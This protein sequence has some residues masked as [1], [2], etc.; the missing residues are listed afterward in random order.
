MY[1]RPHGADR[2][3]HFERVA[4]PVRQSAAV[5]VGAPVRQ[6]RDERREQVAV[7]AVQ[8][9]QIEA[10]AQ[11]HLRG[12]HELLLHAL[13]VVARHRARR[14]IPL[15]VRDRRGAEQRPVAV[16]ERLV[17]LLPAALRRAF[18]SGVAELQRDLRGRVGV[19]EV[20]D[21]RPGR[22]VLLAVHPRA[23]RRD[24]RVG[25]DARHL[26]EHQARAALSARAQVDEIEVVRQ[27]VDA[28]VHRHRRDDDAVRQLELAQ[29]QR[30]EHRRHR[31]R[32]AG[33]RREPRLD[34]GDVRSVAQ[35]QV[36]V[37]EALAAREQAVR[38]LLGLEARVARDVLEPL[39]AVARRVLQ[40]QHLDAAFGLVLLE[41]PRQLGIAAQRAGQADR[42][43]ERELGARADREV[44]RVGGVADQHAV[45]VVPAR[46]A[47]LDE[48]DPRIRQVLGVAHQPVAAEVRREQ[49]L[50]ERDR[51]LRARGVETRRAPG[52]FAALDDH[53]PRV[54]IELIGVHLEP[55]VLGLF[56][57]ERERVEPLVRAQPDVAV[58]AV[59]E[60]GAERVHVLAPGRAVRAVADHD[61]VGAGVVFV[62]R[63]DL[64]AQV[65][66]HRPRAF[67]QDV[68]Q[69]LARDPREAL[70][71]G[72][73]GTP[74]IVHVDVVPMDEALDDS[75]VRRRIGG[76]D[77]SERLIGEDDAP[78]ERVVGAVT[79]EDDDLRG[80]LRPASS[81]SRRT[82]RP[83]RRRCRRFACRASMLATSTIEA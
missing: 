78:A 31:L 15:A 59:L 45:A 70:T 71:A 24:A 25:R 56:E 26:G 23:A 14:L 34:V 30:R 10:A 58:A 80:G 12:A 57:R 19:N 9:E 73:N 4:Q 7:R 68:Q 11:P 54:G 43:L 39:G 27:A 61:Q 37:R 77:V 40:A 75:L 33:A 16:G 74:A 83:A 53:R 21:A 8:L 17:G 63:L 64:E 18:R 52:L 42:V 69:L 76:G 36:V 5:L 50:A 44:R 1:C 13:H 35:P 48:R 49:P 20:D 81:G 32:R 28:A 38:E 79:F 3:E 51:L 55:A 60:R 6:R 82:A 29:P 72:A 41:R 66:T 2:G 62:V 22:D 67:L 46:V 47:H 65:D